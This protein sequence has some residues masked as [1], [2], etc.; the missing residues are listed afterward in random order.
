MTG[1]RWAFA[2]LAIATMTGCDGEST[3]D[4]AWYKAHDTERKAKI[5]ECQNDPG[6]LEHAPNCQNAKEA[7]TELML[8]SKNTR[9]PQF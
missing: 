8:S 6:E 9:I 7:A 3:H 4:V 1:R 5:L 2:L